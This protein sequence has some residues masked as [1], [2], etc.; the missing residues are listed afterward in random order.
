MLWSPFTFGYHKI[1]AWM[2][3]PLTHLFLGHL[4]VQLDILQSDET[5]AGSYHIVTTS[6][7]NTIL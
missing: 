2:I 3:L 4:Y 5:Q 6:I 7:H 1:F